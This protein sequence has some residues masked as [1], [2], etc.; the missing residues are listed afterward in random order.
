MAERIRIVIDTR[1]EADAEGDLGWFVDEWIEC[2]DG[3]GEIPVL[4]LDG[5][6]TILGCECWWEFYDEDSCLTLE[7]A[8]V[9]AMEKIDDINRRMNAE[10]N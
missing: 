2:E 1:E 4:Y 9:E 8:Q 6:D 7:E 3:F 5:G 10:N